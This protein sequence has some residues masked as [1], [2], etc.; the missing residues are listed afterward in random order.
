MGLLYTQRIVPATASATSAASGFAATNV[1]LQALGAPW[2]SAATTQQDVIIDLGS[3]QTPRGIGVQD[4]NATSIVIA[5]SPDN[6]AYTD[7]ATLD[8]TNVDRF[9]RRRGC[10]GVNT[11][12]RYWRL[13]IANGTPPD[14]LAYWRIGAVYV[15]GAVATVLN[16]DYG[17]AIETRHAENREGVANGS[18]AIAAVGNR[19]DVITG[20]LRLDASVGIGS[21][22]P[23]LRQGVTWLD[24]QVP[25]R[26]WWTW[27]LTNAVGSDRE[28]M[29][30]AAQAMLDLNAR[31]VVR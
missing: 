28:S 30:N 18:E 29:E 23:D 25:M 16:P 12:A 27:P 13:R 21:L 7:R 20:K 2:R 10:A 3:A 22:L 19:F 11:S 6:I 26:N 8:L 1:L 9:G 31:E 24:L 17:F 15:F 14:G 4:T 5:S